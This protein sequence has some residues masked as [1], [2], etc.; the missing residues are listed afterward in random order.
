MKK[1]LIII[2]L[3]IFSTSLFGQWEQIRRKE[4]FKDSTSH[5]KDVNFVSSAR[6]QSTIKIGSVTLLPTGTEL[7]YVGGVTS[8]IQTQLNDTVSG[9]SIYSQFTDTIP[10]FT[11]GGG[12]GGAGDTSCF[13]T[14]RFYGSFFNKGSDTLVITSMMNILHGSS[15]SVAVDVCWHTTLG[16]G[17]A[18]HLNS[19]P[20]TI[21]SITTGNEDTSFNNAKI[22]PNVFVWCTLTTVTVQPTYFSCTISGHKINKY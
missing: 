11:F 15:A 6:F 10:L 12:S 17:S 1:K 21:T 4:N 19:T 3:T 5:A 16:S 7:N 18:T 9:N 14:G 22:P 8:A 13:R 2:C 20:P